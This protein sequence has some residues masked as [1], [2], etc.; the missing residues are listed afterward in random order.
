[1]LVSD[2]NCKVVEG[3]EREWRDA[4]CKKDMEQLHSL[5]H[6]DFVLI[7]TRSTGPFMMTRDEW[8]DAIQRRDV[9]SIELEVRDATSLD[10]VMVGTVQAKWRLKYLSRIIEDCVL[11]TD[12]WV[13]DGDRWRAIRRH[14]TPAP[15]SDSPGS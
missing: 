2:P 8:L 5:V 4:L 10:Q 6:K 3:L 9:D 13:K 7:G 14:S 15:A 1:R 11:L 12:V